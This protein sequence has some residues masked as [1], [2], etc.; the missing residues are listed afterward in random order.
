MGRANSSVSF[1]GRSHDMCDLWVRI[2]P[3]RHRAEDR[4]TGVPI[5][6]D[7]NDNTNIKVS[8]D[9]SIPQPR[10]RAAYFIPVMEW[11]RL[12]RTISK[13]A[14]PKNWFQ[15]AGSLCAGAAI[16]AAIGLMESDAPSLH[17]REVA[18]IVLVVGS[19]LAAALFLLDHQQ[20]ADIKRSTKGV[21]DEM[22]ELEKTYAD[23]SDVDASPPA[24]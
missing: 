1:P 21:I 7:S 4:R 20:R 5:V 12:K 3:K 2:S 10:P 24:T 13:I 17:F 15:V 22:K 23:Q 14:P 6:V 19:V 11:E 9:Y 18:W 8:Q 16:A